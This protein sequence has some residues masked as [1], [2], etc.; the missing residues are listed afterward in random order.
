MGDLY[1]YIIADIPGIIEGASEGKGLGIKF[2]RHI[3]RTKILA[4]L[5]SFEYAIGGIN[6]MIKRNIKKF[7]KN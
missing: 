4:H 6:N 3:K 2:L 7:A 1:G 5:I